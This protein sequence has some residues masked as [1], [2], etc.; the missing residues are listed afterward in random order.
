MQFIWWQADGSYSEPYKP[1]SR[2]PMDFVKPFTKVTAVCWSF[3]LLQ[4]QEAALKEALERSHAAHAEAMKEAK[5]EAD[6]YQ[7]GLADRARSKFVA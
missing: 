3:D 2:K 4:W 7:R 6:D 1:C 5:A